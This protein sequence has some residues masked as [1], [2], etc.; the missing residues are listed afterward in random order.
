MPES[1][2]S[3]GGPRSLALSTAEQEFLTSGTLGG[4]RKSRLEDRVNTKVKGLPDRLSRLVDDVDLISTSDHLDSEVRQQ[5]W[6]DLLRETTPDHIE[7]PEMDLLQ[8]YTTQRPLTPPQE[9]GQFI[10][11][12]THDLLRNP[13]DIDREEL[14]AHVIFGFVKGIYVNTLLAGRVNQQGIDFETKQILESVQSLASEIEEHRTDLSNQTGDWRMR[15]RKWLEARN[16]FETSVQEILADE[17]VSDASSL[18][19]EQMVGCPDNNGESQKSV[20]EIE[21]NNDRDEVELLT[22]GK[23]DEM[24]KKSSRSVAG[25][26]M[27]HLI[28]SEVETDGIPG[29]WGI[30]KSFQRMHDVNEFVPNEFVTRDSVMDVLQDRRI[31]GRIGLDLWLESDSNRLESH[32]WRGIDAIDV[33][34]AVYNGGPGSSANIERK[35]NLKGQKTS[36]VTRVSRDLADENPLER[37]VWDK[38]P[39]LHGN[40]D[41]WQLT[42]YGEVLAHYLFDHDHWSIDAMDDS[43]I[44]QG[45]DEL[46]KVNILPDEPGIRG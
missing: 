32:H 26:T 38:L 33:F 15:N 41:K 46:L 8:L 7:A 2:R 12:F 22:R 34:E 6:K 44:Y 20:D 23:I 21:A 13:A 36:L 19:K 37:D 28:D 31:V 16:Q 25:K 43:I 35:L 29:T 42:P 39:L 14:I 1:N 10:G 27:S 3:S 9:L 4:Y 11:S 30:E 40:T 17:G 5:V 45:I 18:F 24:A